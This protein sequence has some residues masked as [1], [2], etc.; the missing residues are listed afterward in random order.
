MSLEMIVFAN[1]VEDKLIPLWINE[2]EQLGMICE[3]HPEFSFGGQTGFLPIKLKLL[4]PCHDDWIDKYF[5]TGFEFYLHDFDLSE[6]LRAR[7][8]KQPFWNPFFGKG[9]TVTTPFISSEIDAQLEQYNK[10][11]SLIWGGSD[12][13]ELR[14]A[15]TSAAILAKLTGGLCTYQYEEW[16][17]DPEEAAKQFVIDADL[18][19]RS[20]NP[21]KQEAV[22]FKGWN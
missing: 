2:F 21:S 19:E 9:N 15:T 17:K 5:L 13:F 22:E 11:I 20:V 4:K 7:Q 6:E 12:P 1:D 16:Y 8:P 10:M 3:L 14:I 18:Y